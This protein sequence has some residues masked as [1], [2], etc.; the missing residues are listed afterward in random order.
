MVLVTLFWLALALA[1]LA[2]GVYVVRELR[3]L[4]EGSGWLWPTFIALILL[5]PSEIWRFGIRLQEDAEGVV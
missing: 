1:A 5:A 2:S 4:P 3:R